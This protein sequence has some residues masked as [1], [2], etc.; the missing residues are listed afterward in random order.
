MESA[1]VRRVGARVATRRGGIW[2]SSL[3][4]VSI[5][6][7][8]GAGEARLFSG[9]VQR[10]LPAPCA[11]CGQPAHAQETPIWKMGQEQAPLQCTQ[12]PPLLAWLAPLLPFKKTNS[13]P[14]EQPEPQAP[15]LWA[16]WRTPKTVPEG[17]GLE[18][19]PGKLTVREEVL[20][21]AAPWLVHAAI[22]DVMRYPEWSGGVKKI[23][24]LGGSESAPELAYI[25]RACG[26]KLDFSLLWDLQELDGPAELYT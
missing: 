17:E 20:I 18:L 15:S 5:C 14:E 25:A 8:I 2:R 11:S 6:V 10:S 3:V 7:C 22:S 21:S 1:A 16:R 13:P 24:P 26:V 19:P 23:S 12:K 4:A 9:L